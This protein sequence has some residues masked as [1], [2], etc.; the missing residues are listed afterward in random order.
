MEASEK[1][2]EV[3][4]KRADKQVDKQM[5][6]RQGHLN[7]SVFQAAVGHGAMAS[8]LASKFLLTHFFSVSLFLSSPFPYDLG[9][10]VLAAAIST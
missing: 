3:K 4:T 9:C 5:D 1:T 2:G 10:V 7:T 6:E 8:Q